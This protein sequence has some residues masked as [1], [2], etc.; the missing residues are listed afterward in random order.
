M[1]LKRE[2]T[3]KLEIDTD[4][5]IDTTEPNDISY[6]ALQDITLREGS[7]SG[8]LEVPDATGSDG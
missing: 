2:P 7:T 3:P 5:V 1:S 8:S 6:A 4:V